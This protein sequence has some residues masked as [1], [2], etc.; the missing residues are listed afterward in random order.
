M[1]LRSLTTYATTAASVRRVI[2]AQPVLIAASAT[3]FHALSARADTEN[4][5]L[6]SDIAMGK[7]RKDGKQV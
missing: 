1:N 3:Q 7:K 5:G 6:E 2:G 4:G